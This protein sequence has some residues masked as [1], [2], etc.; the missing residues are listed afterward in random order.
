VGVASSYAGQWNWNACPW[1]SWDRSR[2]WHGR[3][4]SE[5]CW[6]Q[7]QGTT[8]ADG[9]RGPSPGN[10]V[11]QAT[12]MTPTATDNQANAGKTAVAANMLT[13]VFF[14]LAY[15]KAYRPITGHWKQHNAA[16]KWFRLISERGQANDASA[17][18]VF[19]NHEAV[20]VATI[21]HDDVGTD[22]KFD[23][24]AMVPWKWHEMIA[25]MDA[26]AMEHVVCGPDGRSGGVGACSFSARHNSYDHKRAHA[27]VK[28]GRKTDKKQVWDFVVHRADGS[29][30]RLHP[31]WSKTHIETFEAQGHNHAVAEPDEGCGQSWGPGTFRYYVDVANRRTLRFN[32]QLKPEPKAAPPMPKAKP[33]P[34]VASSAVAASSWD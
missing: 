25:H 9:E 3:S 13:S 15:F 24:T 17:E 21:M 6:K 30:I 1:N 18:I 31:N 29:A 19:P 8:N 11:Q 14:D 22:F 27:D 33:Q 4:G 2:G 26:E 16:L 34:P 7:Q 5:T 28:V 10:L 12:T 23:E 32:G 20:A